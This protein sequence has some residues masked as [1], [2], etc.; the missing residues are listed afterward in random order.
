MACNSMTDVW[1]FCALCV[2]ISRFFKVQ[3]DDFKPQQK[4]TY[5]NIGSQS[6]PG[7][8]KK[9]FQNTD[10]FSG[11]NLILQ[12]SSAFISQLHRMT[13]EVTCFRAATP[14]LVCNFQA[15]NK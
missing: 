9:M 6:D 12:Q 14:F 5:D 7:G 13:G 2:R 3:V 10:V 1:V 15:Q 4:E 11:E 8:K